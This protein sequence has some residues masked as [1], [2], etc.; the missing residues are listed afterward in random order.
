LTVSAQDAELSRELGRVGTDQLRETSGLA[1]SRQNPDILWLHNDG[2][3]KHIYAVRT[4]GRPAARLN[5]R[6]KF[7]D[8]ED[9][10]I[11]LGPQ[12]GTDFLYLGDIGDNK[13]DRRE[14]RIV[15]VPEPS[16]SQSDDEELKI[17]D[18]EVFRLRYP[19]GPHDAEALMIDSATGDLFIATKSPRSSRLYHAALDDLQ[20]GGVTTLELAANLD[21]D[22]ISAG[23]ISRTGD[24]IILRSEDRGWLWARQPGEEVAAALERAPVRVLTH[25]RGQ[26]KNGESIGF[27]PDGRGYFTISEGKHEVMYFFPVVGSDPD[28]SR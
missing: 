6:T 15:R 2:A 9:I 4:D 13:E 18:P 23:D 1:V 7:D 25:G 22:D 8:I 16:L 28:D 27:A 24:W 10:A 14:I 3:K 11:G 19:D 17:K 12:P 21:V 20:S 5:V 26:G